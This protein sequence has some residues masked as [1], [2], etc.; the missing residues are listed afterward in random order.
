[1]KAKLT[2]DEWSE[3]CFCVFLYYSQVQI[4]NWL[5]RSKEFLVTMSS[6]VDWFMYDLIV[7]YTLVDE[8][9]KWMVMTKL[10]KLA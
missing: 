8:H 5:S 2:A 3:A 6:R 10:T 9:D 7:W 4:L 1:M